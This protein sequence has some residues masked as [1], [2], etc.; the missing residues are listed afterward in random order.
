MKDEFV[1]WREVDAREQARLELVAL[2][3]EVT[4]VA[5]LIDEALGEIA[6]PGAMELAD[7]A[8]ALAERAAS[9]LSRATDFEVLRGAVLQA[10]TA[11]L[12]HD[13][14]QMLRVREEATDLVNGQL[15]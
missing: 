3:C 5:A 7:K 15:P 4:T 10:A 11:D 13:R 2:A 12:R 9:V 6:D 1:A 14:E 8:K